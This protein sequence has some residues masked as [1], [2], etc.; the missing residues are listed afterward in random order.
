MQVIVPATPDGLHPRTI[1]AILRAGYSP[2]VVPMLEV[3]SYFDLLRHQWAEGDT[4]AIVEHDIEVGPR[5]LRELEECPHEWCAFS[6]EVFA[7]D[8]ATAYGGPFGLG[9][10]RFRAGLLE[11]IADAVT[12]AGTYDQHPVHPPRSYAVMDSSLTYV[13]RAHGLTPCHHGPN[14]AHHH[15]Y[16]REGAYVPPV[17]NAAGGA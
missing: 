16:M 1:P 9:C 14:V 10:C 12:Q 13:L 17:A 6:Y 5:S 2:E 8:L 15:E 4:F 3:E 11:R 7:G